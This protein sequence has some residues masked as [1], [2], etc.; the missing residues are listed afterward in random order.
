MIYD[1]PLTATM[2]CGPLLV[3]L[4]YHDVPD[5]DDGD[6]VTMAVVDFRARTSDVA[7]V[8]VR[9]NQA[10]RAGYMPVA[11]LL[12]A[13]AARHPSRSRNE[14]GV[15]KM[16][17]DGV[18][19]PEPGA[20]RGGPTA[21][22]DPQWYFELLRGVPGFQ[23]RPGASAARVRGCANTRLAAEMSSNGREMLGPGY[24][25]IDEDGPAVVPMDEIP[26]EVT[27]DSEG[28]VTRITLGEPGEAVAKPRTLEVVER[29]VTGGVLDSV[30]SRYRFL[31]KLRAAP[32][33]GRS[34]E[35][36]DEG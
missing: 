11:L 34:I 36:A 29:H 21:A 1:D 25:L 13:L 17:R 31:R 30:A 3:R 7:T 35:S 6:V 20:V 28:C 19:T 16:L 4:S 12:R 32:P 9:R 22:P 10:R 33:I 27:T 8:F 24:S 2:A 14:D 5:P 15:G 26:V 23:P 18:W